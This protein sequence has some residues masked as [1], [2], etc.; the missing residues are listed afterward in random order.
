MTI[1]SYEEILKMSSQYD[2][3]PICR[4]VYADVVT[5]ITLLRRLA[6]QSKRFYLL[7][8][9]EGGEKWGRYSFLGYD[10]VLRVIC[11]LGNVRI[12]SQV[13]EIPSRQF[14][15]D[16][17]LQVVREILSLYKS[18]RL[19]GQ[20]PFTGGFVGYFAYAMLGYAEPTLRISR[21]EANDYDLMLFDKVIAYDHLKQKISIVVN[22]KT[23]RNG[24]KKPGDSGR[25]GLLGRDQKVRTGT[26]ER[27]EET[28]DL[29]YHMKEYG[30][31][32]QDIETIAAII[33]DTSP[34]EK[35]VSSEKPIFTCNVSKEEYCRIVEQTKEYILE[36]DIFQAV[37]SRQFTSS[38]EGSLLNAYRVLRTTN[39]SPYMVYMNI[40]QDEIISASPET[41]VRLNNGRLTTFPVAGSRPR[42]ATEEEDKRLE[43][44]L[45]ADE[46]ELAEHNMLVDLGRN[47]IG[48]IAEF[49]S[50]EVTEYQMVHKYSK[51][52]HICSQVEGDIRCG[53]DGCSAVEA[54][55]PAGTLTGA[56]KIRA[57]EII[58]EMEG[59]PRGVYGGALGY[60]DF[61]GNLDTCIAIRMA[62][63]QNGRVTVQ[64]GGGIVA[65]SIPEMEYEESGNKAMAVINAIIHAGEV[66]DK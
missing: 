27:P 65:D 60:L 30:R 32:C 25:R 26:D 40:D 57:C 41:L 52:M 58:E 2:I 4:E 46:K 43:L 55:L 15:T 24:K 53:F 66:N 62:V 50:V 33:N 45:M 38:Y 51:I 54:L 29:E 39:P 49:G 44:E 1:P 13:E 8:S 61:T 47:D 17:P 64:A 20:P 34:L 31:A 7:E 37:I 35:L 16:N 42:G 14:M 56:P 9:I 22:M 6:R 10:P 5:P 28:Q 63:K 59:E 36:G 21:G 18:P 19:K 12:E 11:K 3:I 48:R 23:R